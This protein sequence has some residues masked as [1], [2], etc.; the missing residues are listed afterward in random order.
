MDEHSIRLIYSMLSACDLYLEGYGTISN[1]QNTV[2]SNL[3]AMDSIHERS[4]FPV[5]NNFVEELESLQFG[6]S[7]D[8]YFDKVKEEISNFKADLRERLETISSM[9]TINNDELQR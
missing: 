6:Y 3:E 4:L 8:E 2:L 1:L 5:T 7:S 9:G